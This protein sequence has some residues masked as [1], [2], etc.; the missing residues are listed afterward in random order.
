[1]NLDLEIENSKEYL[2]YSINQTVEKYNFNY[3]SKVKF[4]NY[5][6][7]RS[8][9]IILKQNELS[10][11]GVGKIYFESNNYFFT[12]QFN[13]KEFTKEEY[14]KNKQHSKMVYNGLY[15]HPYY[16]NKELFKQ[17]NDL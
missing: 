4:T 2:I 16:G 12:R 13:G 17:I 15:N 14:F 6:Y 9:D 5:N 7:F 10:K 1:M 3:H 11:L 8:G